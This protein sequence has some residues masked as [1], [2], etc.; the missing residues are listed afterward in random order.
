LKS[1]EADKITA[2]NDLSAVRGLSDNEIRDA[3]EE[4]KRSTA[5]IEKQSE[6]LGLQQNAMKMLMKTNGRTREARVC[7]DKSQQ[8][9]WDVEKS[10]MIAAVSLQVAGRRSF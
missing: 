7:V 6:A 9:K 5:A 4:L 8:R 10:H 1:G 2:A 3:I